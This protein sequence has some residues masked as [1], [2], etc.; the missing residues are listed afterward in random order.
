[1][2]LRVFPMRSGCRAPHHSGR[3]ATI[4][5]S[6]QPAPCRWGQTKRMGNAAAGSGLFSVN[7]S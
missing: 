7:I 5:A 4:R 6:T 3:P 1:M 2:L